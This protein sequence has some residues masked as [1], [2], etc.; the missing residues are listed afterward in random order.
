MYNLSGDELTKLVKQRKGVIRKEAKKA[1]G[2]LTVEGNGTIV[3]GNIFETENGIRYISTEQVTIT[4]TE[5]VKVEAVI[6]R[7]NG[8]VGANSITVITATIQGSSK[9]TNKYQ[10]IDG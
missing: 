7:I 8:N 6:E 5:T 10:F 4:G 3:D 1:K 9:V 2:I